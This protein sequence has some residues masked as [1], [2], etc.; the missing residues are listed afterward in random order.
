MTNPDFSALFKEMELNIIK[1]M[2]QIGAIPE[3]LS[4][5]MQTQTA[6]LPQGPTLPGAGGVLPGS[7]PME[8][9]Q[10]QQYMQMQQMQQQQIKK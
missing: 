4:Q 7:N 3:Q 5:Y 1:L 10:L 2:E 9:L 6:N 8:M